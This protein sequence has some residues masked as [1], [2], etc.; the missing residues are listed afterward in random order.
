MNTECFNLSECSQ[1]QFYECSQKQFYEYPT[2]KL[3]NNKI[4]LELDPINDEDYPFISIVTPFYNR[5]KFIDLMINNFNNINYPRDKIEWVIIDDSTEKSEDIEKLQHISELKY[6]HLN[7]HITIG[8]KRNLLAK[9]AT[10]DYIVHFDDDDFYGSLSV[11]ARIRALLYLEKRNINSIVGCSRVNCYDILTGAEFEAFDIINGVSEAS[12]SESTMA[13]NK[14]IFN[15]QQF[16]N[17][18]K[19]SEGLSFIKGRTVYTL[20]SSFIV[21]QLSHGYN[22][23]KREVTGI[24]MQNYFIKNLSINDMKVI[25]NLKCSLIYSLPEFKEAV[26][27]SKLPYGEL[28]KFFKQDPVKMYNSTYSYDTLYKNPLLIDTR[29]TLYEN[30]N[31]KNLDKK[32]LDKRIINYYCGPGEFFKFSAKWNLDKLGGSE[33]AVINLSKLFEKKGYHT[34]IYIVTDKTIKYSDNIIIRPYYEW[35]PCNYV[36]ITIIWRDPTNITSN[37]NS[38]KII[39]DLHDHFTENDINLFSGISNTYI[40]TKSLYHMIT[41]NR[42]VNKSNKLYKNY[43]PIHSSVVDISNSIIDLKEKVKYKLICTSSPDRCI[44]ALLKALPIIQKEL[45]DTELYWAYGFKSGIN[46]GGILSNTS[47]E[48]K[49]FMSSVNELIDTKGFYNLDR[50]TLNE[51]N[52]L[53]KTGDLFIYGTRFPEIDCISLSKAMYYGCIP[54]VTDTGAM[55]EKVTD[56][57]KK[58]KLNIPLIKVNKESNILDKSID[59]DEFNE[60]VT[61]IINMLKDNKRDTYR[62]AI[63]NYANSNYMNYDEWNKIIL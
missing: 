4:K 12:I 18:D 40:M 56:L 54:I 52:D 27:I 8:H 26:K 10:H 16:D 44:L 53:Y 51:V 38:D 32:L 21:T 62:E 55:K 35:I 2:T 5:H 37:I 43:N 22:T 59:G 47:Y 17:E 30:T 45:P 20:P 34:N 9:Y 42:L 46:E 19:F 7:N 39:L 50:L 41:I 61:T 36:D 63:H 31:K 24:S 57:N 49:K 25:E 15:E 11:V 48:A 60:W 28:I 14:K 58:T 33:E 1:K 29:R 13:Y 3:P 23:I 6:I